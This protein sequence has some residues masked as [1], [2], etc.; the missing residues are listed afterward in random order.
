MFDKFIDIL[1]TILKLA[2]LD[3]LFLF[4]EYKLK[5]DVKKLAPWEKILYYGT[6]TLYIVFKSLV[7]AQISGYVDLFKLQFY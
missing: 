7:Y 6:N 1:L 4:T 2:F 3:I 5:V